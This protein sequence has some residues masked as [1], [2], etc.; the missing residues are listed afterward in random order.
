M[1]ALEN[2]LTV[3]CDVQVVFSNLKIFPQVVADSYGGYKM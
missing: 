1:Y 2:G 3:S